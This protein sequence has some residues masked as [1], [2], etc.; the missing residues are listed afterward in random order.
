MQHKYQ[1]DGPRHHGARALVGVILLAV[2]VWVFLTEGAT[3]SGHP[4]RRTSSP[5]APATTVPA[6]G[7][8]PAVPPTT[9][10]PST[11]VP[12]TTVPTTTAPPVPTTRPPVP[13]STTTTTRPRRARSTTTLPPAVATSSTIARA[14]RPPGAGTALHSAGLS[15]GSTTPTTATKQTRR[16]REARVPTPISTLSTGAARA[17]TRSTTTTTTTTKTKTKT[18]LA[19]STGALVVSSAGSSDQRPAKTWAQRHH[20]AVTPAPQNC[21]PDPA[22]M[23]EALPAGAVFHGSGCYFTSG[24]VITK[25]VTI[26]G[27]TYYNPATDLSAQGRLFPIIQVKDT[28]GVTI[29]NTSLQGAN[30]IG[31]F[32]RHLVGESGLDI[33]SASDVTITNVATVNTF[34]D[35]MTV[36][37]AFGTSNQPTTNLLVNGLDITQAGRQG[38]TMAYARDSTLNGVRV[39]SASG[40]GWDFESDL[41]GIGSGNITVNGA[42]GTK[43]IRFIE[44]LQGPVT[45]NDCQC[46]RHV[47]LSH[48]AAA[49]GQPVTFNRG[50]LMLPRGDHGITPAGV[51]VTGPG[52]L[53]LTDVTL[54]NLPGTR[55]VS[56]PTWSI[57]GGGHLTLTG[58]PAPTGGRHD[59]TSTVVTT[60]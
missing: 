43:G 10:P 36:F 29:E 11:T 20:V 22:A 46:Q 32:H 57:T 4:D 39:N 34:G 53:R 3:A 21:Q 44:A 25:P 17:R 28:S 23:I 60:P 27:G 59:A 2:L 31:G 55:T 50:T 16:Q 41:P 13:L 54:G 51:I 14:A 18:T 49:S 33:L 8:V 42:S 12:L 40:S 58:T 19:S 15:P 47:T 7:S 26:D 37:A 5:V 56:G 52:N 6:P 35:G 30:S 45:F 1:A 38:I 24:I 9:V 48:E